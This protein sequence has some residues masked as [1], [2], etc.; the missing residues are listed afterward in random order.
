MV[1]NREDIP[2]NRENPGD[3]VAGLR[4]LSALR[5]ARWPA[6]YPG[7]GSWLLDWLLRPSRRRP[8]TVKWSPTPTASHEKVQRFF[9]VAR[10]G[11]RHCLR[12]LFCAWR[13]RL[14]LSRAA[15]GRHWALLR[16]GF[17]ADGWCI[18][19]LIPARPGPGCSGRKPTREATSALR[20]ASTSAFAYLKFV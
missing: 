17:F 10:S 16:Q 2:S 13:R 20:P 5:L 15:I 19:L 9:K 12:C 4:L 7:D 1:T 8:G 3:R 6:R 18:P 11:H 14:E